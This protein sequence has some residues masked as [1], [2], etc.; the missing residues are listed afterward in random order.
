M[1]VAIITDTHFC[2]KKSNKTYHDYFEKFYKN[3]FFPALEERQI[4][5][6]IHMGDAFDNRR[7]V[8]YWGL[9]WAQRVVYNK[10]RDLDITV[11]QIMGN[12]DA[13]HKT[14]NDINSI[15]TLLHHYENVIPVTDPKEF[16]IGDLK[17]LLLPWICKENEERTFKIV[18]NT[19]AKVIFGHLELQGFSL[20]PGQVQTHGMS[21]EKFQKFDRVFT[22]HYHTRSSDG[23]V[24]YL[25]NPYQMFWSDV[26]DKRGFHIFDTETYELEFVENPY[27]MF[28][29][30]YY[31]DLDF[32]EFDFS[33]LEDKNIKILV[34]KKTD[35]LK[36]EKFI[37]NILKEKIVDLK[38]TENTNLDLNN[39]KIDDNDSEDTLSVLN[40][41]IDESDF[42][43][44]KNMIKKILQDTYKEALELEIA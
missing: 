5:S 18:K 35:Q 33:S 21:S 25:G 20:F 23:K 24:F 6:V 11:Y 8:D 37:S 17:C 12:H 36:Y 41:Y 22:G 44:N 9:E 1:K 10:L 4:D 38:I 16:I 31:S 28:R 42:N 19:K 29:K 15:E 32:E 43:L 40:K 14:T 39:L 26:D 7:G 13:Y 30:I 3:V 2:F 34:T 27:T